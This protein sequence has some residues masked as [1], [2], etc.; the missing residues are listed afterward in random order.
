[1]ASSLVDLCHDVT[2]KVR[3]I[4]PFDQEVQINQDTVVG[5]AEKVEEQPILLFSSENTKDS[6]NFD[7]ERRIQFESNPVTWQTNEGII[8]NITKSRRDGVEDHTQFLVPFLLKRE[9]LEKMHNS[10]LS[11][12]LGKKKTKA[13][14]S[15]RYFWY[16]MREDID[17]WISKCD[18]CGAN[19]HPHKP[20]RAPLGTMPVGAPL[21]RLAT[22]FLGPL[23]TTPRGNKFILTV[24]D[25]FRKWVEVFP[26]KD[27]TA[28]VCAQLILNEVICR[29]GSPLAIH[30]DQGRTY[31]SQIFQELCKILEI[32]KTRTS[33][34]NPKC[35]GQTERFNRSIISMIKT[36]LRGEQTNW[37]M[38][39]GCLAGAYRASPNESTCLTPNILMLGRKQILEALSTFNTTQE[40]LLKEISHNTKSIQTLSTDIA[41]LRG[42][43]RQFERVQGRQQTIQDRLSNLSNRPFKP[44]RRKP[45]LNRPKPQQRQPKVKSVVEKKNDSKEN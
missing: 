33:P 45:Y 42:Q 37:D 38:N 30:S 17:I 27:Q 26:V 20:S 18:I 11:G 3:L 34:R 16:E 29:F 10:I 32:R 9:I 43:V 4:N 28:V 8:R 19:K 44:I 5:L 24:T 2:N 36:Y 35:N 1:M 14:L 13:K 6:T 21:D 39:L 12:H 41:Y 40:L 7:S 31:E 23:P 15:Q 22:D 25:Y